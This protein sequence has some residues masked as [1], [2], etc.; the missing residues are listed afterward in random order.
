MVASVA[1]IAGAQALPNGL[2]YACVNNNSGTIHVIAAGGACANNEVQLV[3]NQQG[4]KGDPGALGPQGPV[5]PSGPAGLQ[6]TTGPQGVPGVPGP[7]GLPGAAGSQ[8]PQGLTGPIAIR[9]FQSNG[10]VTIPNGVNH[11]LVEA[12]GGGGGSGAS[13]WQSTSSNVSP[14]GGGGGAGAYV[15]AIIEVAPGKSYRVTVGQGGAAGSYGAGTT[16]AAGTESN[17][18]GPRWHQTRVGWRRGS[19]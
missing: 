6:G 12:W 1:T 3:W 15:R 10:V 11:I 8:G 14:S 4:P 19:R 16:A 9:E 13:C 2:I 7:A 18:V 17:F 5:G